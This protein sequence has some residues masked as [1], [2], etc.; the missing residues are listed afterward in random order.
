MPTRL[1]ASTVSAG[2]RRAIAMTAL[3]LKSRPES[4]RVR[5]NSYHLTSMP[6]CCASPDVAK[7]SVASRLATVRIHSIQRA[8]RLRHLLPAR[9]RLFGRLRDLRRDV[10][11][12]LVELLGLHAFFL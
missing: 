12:D 9:D 11:L 2:P 10:S 6:R 1:S 8:L 5:S 3:P 7:R 4:G